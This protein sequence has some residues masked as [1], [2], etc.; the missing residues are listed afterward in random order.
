[1]SILAGAT[2]SVTPST[3]AGGHVL[4]PGRKDRESA[5]SAASS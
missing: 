2:E 1:M 4:K 3:T 5:A